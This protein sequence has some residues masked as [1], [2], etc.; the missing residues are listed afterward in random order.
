MITDSKD[1]L[2]KIKKCTKGSKVKVTFEY[3]GENQIEEGIVTSISQSQGQMTIETDNDVLEFDFEDIIDIEMEKIPNKIRTLVIEKG[4]GSTITIPLNQIQ[5]MFEGTE[6]LMG[7]IYKISTAAENGSE[8]YVS[9][10]TF[11]ELQR[12]FEPV[13][14]ESRE[15]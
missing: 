7:K 4:D 5:W 9:E 10:E 12:Y 8:D 11:R 6:P 13:V 14:I 1:V 3:E 2:N 15:D